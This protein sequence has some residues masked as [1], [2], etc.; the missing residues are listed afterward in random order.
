V[1]VKDYAL[2]DLLCVYPDRPPPLYLECDLLLLATCILVISAQEFRAGRTLRKK[3]P[4]QPKTKI[5]I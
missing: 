5:S 2:P 1:F 4:E 3:T